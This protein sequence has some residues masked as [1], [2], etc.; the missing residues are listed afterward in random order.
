MA[1]LH[2]HN[3]PKI[4][5]GIIKSFNKQRIKRY[6]KK[7]K[8]DDPDSSKSIMYKPDYVIQREPTKFTDYFI[9]F[10]IID[11]QDEDKTAHDLI[12]I[13]GKR[14]IRKAIFISCSPPW[15]I[16]VFFR[17]RACSPQVISDTEGQT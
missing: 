14:N 12:K 4:I 15:G 17:H 11:K 9:I 6:R 3:I 5:D 1:S 2:H 10:E 7:I 13:I 16:G 8:L